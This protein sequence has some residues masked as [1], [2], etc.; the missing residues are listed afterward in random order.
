MLLQIETT[1]ANQGNCNYKIGHL[2]QIGA[3]CITNW[4]RYY[5]LGQLLQIG[6]KQHEPKVNDNEK[7]QVT[8]ET[9]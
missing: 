2:L 3:K 1:I 7:R 8:K 9:S 4:V 6:A 5:K